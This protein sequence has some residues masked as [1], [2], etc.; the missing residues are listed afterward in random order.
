M[1]KTPPLTRIYHYEINEEGE[2]LFEGKPLLDEK[3][4]G[5]FLRHLRPIDEN[6]SDASPITLIK[7]FT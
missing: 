3:T 2:L 1:K 4:I 7:K 5:F 6:D